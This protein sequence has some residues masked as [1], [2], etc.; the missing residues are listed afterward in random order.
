MQVVTVPPVISG[1][2]L[3]RANQ[4]LTLEFTG[5]PGQSYW[6]Q[7]ATQL[8]TNTVWETIST[9]VADL[10]NGRFNFILT[11]TAEFPQRYFRT[12]KP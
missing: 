9:N 12:V 7:G 1:W 4:T 6:I 11:N 5:T 3:D 2:M 10:Q 8:S